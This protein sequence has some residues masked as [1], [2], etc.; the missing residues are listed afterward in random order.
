M[1]MEVLVPSLPV[2]TGYT[3]REIT[4]A[5]TPDDASKLSRIQQG[6]VDAAEC[7]SDGCRVESAADVFKA[8]IQCA[9]VHEAV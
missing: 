9:R 8:L 4:V 5:L 6:L 2:Y 7:H 1:R 3:P